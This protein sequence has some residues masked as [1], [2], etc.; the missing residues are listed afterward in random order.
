[1]I[2]EENKQMTTQ[3]KIEC[4]IEGFKSMTSKNGKQFW[5]IKTSE[6]KY[7]TWNKDVVDML[8]YYLDGLCTIVL[9]TNDKGFT[10]L[11]DVRRDEPVGTHKENNS[12][13]HKV[14][15]PDNKSTTMYTS[16]AKDIFIA[17]WT[18]HDQDQHT[19]MAQ[20]ISLVKQAKEAFS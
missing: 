1:M 20:A 4:T 16:Y 3:N 19:V 11:I 12:S 17:L 7:N 6:G 10:T 13:V 9:E 8:E 18:G 15:Y 5:Q 14:V 2:K